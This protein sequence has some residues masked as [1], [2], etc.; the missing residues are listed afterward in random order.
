LQS[1][2]IGFGGTWISEL[3]TDL[4]VKVI[5]R[6]F[7]LGINYFDTA[8]L[9]GDSEEK[10]GTALKAVRDECIIATKTASRTKNESLKD[11]KSSLLRLKTDRLDVIQLHG[12]DDEKTLNKAI[13]SNGSLRMCKRARSEGLVNYIGITSHKPRVLVE[14]IKTNEFDTI[15][16][17]LNFVTRQALEKLIPLAKEF[18]IGVAI[19]KPLS[20]KTS[21]IITC[22]Y[23]PSLS[24]LSDEPDLKALLGQEINSMVRSALSFVLSQD[25]CVAVTGFKS[26][27]EVEIA[28]EVGE[29]YSGLTNEEQNHFF[30]QF[31]KNCCRDCGLCLPCP[32]N[33]DIAA[34]LRFHMLY[35]IYNLKEWATKLYNGLEV[36]V[37]KCTKCGECELKCPYS[38]SIMSMLQEIE[39]Y[40]YR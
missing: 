39:S 32:Q 7:E 10:I 14:A 9:D 31:N 25:V 20:A 13:G 8:K 6:A 15:L 17:P 35:T 27:Q 12:I 21:K 40:L 23:Q 19:M 29:N 11:F 28:V 26:V 18:N 36:D 38:L 24:L 3:S 30:A 34:L 4:A 1:S 5:H 37:T 22:L 16:V 33:L 2:I